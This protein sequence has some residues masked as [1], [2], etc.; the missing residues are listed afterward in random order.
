[1]YTVKEDSTLH[2]ALEVIEYNHCRAAIVV[3]NNNKLIGSISQGDI[4]RALIKKRG[5]ES[6]IS[7][8]I[9]ISANYSKA[10]KKIDFASLYRKGIT[11]MPIVDDEFYII[12]IIKV[13]DQIKF[14][15]K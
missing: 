7:D 5:Y 13:Q 4:I 6:K 1:M 8:L 3:N 14:E 12:D 10:N 15:N 11:L 9:N 2:E